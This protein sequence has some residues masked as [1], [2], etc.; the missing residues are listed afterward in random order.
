MEN[1]VNTQWKDWTRAEPSQMH[2]HQT[3]A[4]SYCVHPDVV[5]QEGLN[6]TYITFLS[7]TLLKARHEKT[8]NKPKGRNISFKGR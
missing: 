2:H 3:G 1:I 8:S 4:N 6:V 5:P 7:G